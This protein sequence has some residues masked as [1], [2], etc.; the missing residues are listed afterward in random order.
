MNSLGKILVV[1][2][3][4]ISLGFTAFTL[5][6]V[7]GG[8]NWL[9]ESESTE[10]TN[11]FIF[12]KA[13]GEKP[14]YSVKNRRTDASV[15][16][17]TPVLA[18]AVVKARQEQAKLASDKLA[19]LTQQITTIKPQIEAIKSLIPPDDAG[20]KKRSESYEKHLEKLNADLLVA[21]TE[22]TTKGSEIQQTRRTGQERREEGFRMKNQLELL[23]NDLF[24]AEKQKKVLADELVRMEE[25]LK[26][27]QR[28]EALLKEQVGG[29][30]K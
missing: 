13:S 4:A 9:A 2:V 8:P 19:Q 28:R 20:V 1:F 22:F 27:L 7:T 23:R 14:T 18:E 6:M 15:Q 10:L 11:D 26:R 24:A 25:Y 17:A 5:A 21:T 30:E 29:Y 16:A 12:T 3:T